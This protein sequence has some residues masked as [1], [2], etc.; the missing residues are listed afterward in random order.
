MKNQIFCKSL[1]NSLQSEIKLEGLVHENCN[2]KKAAL[3]LATTTTNNN[4][5]LMFNN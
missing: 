5:I 4:K 3:K 1:Q 2:F